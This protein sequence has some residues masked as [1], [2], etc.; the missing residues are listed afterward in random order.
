MTSPNIVNKVKKL[1]QDGGQFVDL[2]ENIS[3][4]ETDIRFCYRLLYIF[5]TYRY[6]TL[7]PISLYFFLLTAKFHTQAQSK[8][9]GRLHRNL[10]A[11]YLKS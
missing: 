2:G 7:L 9:F 1:I 11:G 10:T 6:K 8:L 3:R 5:F 4:S